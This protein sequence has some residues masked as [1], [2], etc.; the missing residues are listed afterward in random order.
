M[1]NIGEIGGT[2]NLAF[3]IPESRNRTN[4]WKLLEDNFHLKEL[5]GRDFKNGMRCF[6]YEAENHL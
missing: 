1:F 6:L 3:G 5:L 4:G 2:V